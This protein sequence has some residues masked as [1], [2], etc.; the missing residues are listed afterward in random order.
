MTV[1]WD[2]SVEGGRLQGRELYSR[3]EVALGLAQGE[4]NPKPHRRCGCASPM[5]LLMLELVHQWK[6]ANTSMKSPNDRDR[7]GHPNR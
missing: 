6:L 4:M 5:Q 7:Q 2:L 3:R 1:F